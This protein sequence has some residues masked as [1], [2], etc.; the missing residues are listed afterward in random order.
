M[1]VSDPRR[2]GRADCFISLM[3]LLMKVLSPLIPAIIV[4]SI[5]ENG[6]RVSPAGSLEGGGVPGTAAVPIV[7]SAT[8]LG[9]KWRERGYETSIRDKR[10][11]GRLTD[12][13][14]GDYYQLINDAARGR[15]K[16]YTADY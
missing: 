1:F 11:P 12:R 15:R 4:Q 7:V 2:A 10:L 9:D 8:A 3:T 13:L 14:A 6:G 5:R 16:I